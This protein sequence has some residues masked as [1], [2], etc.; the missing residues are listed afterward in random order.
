M[1]LV[2]RR[3]LHHDDPWCTTS[4]LQWCEHLIEGQKG[5]EI[6]GYRRRTRL[7]SRLER[8]NQAKPTHGKADWPAA[9]VRVGEMR[10]Y[11]VESSVRFG[12]QGYLR[13]GVFMISRNI[14]VANDPFGNWKDVCT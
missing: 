6:E 14:V 5:N 3:V 4:H 1:I 8:R 13:S 11:S 10:G 7:Q 2:K 12:P 9:A